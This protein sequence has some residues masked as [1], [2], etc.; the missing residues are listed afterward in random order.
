MHILAKDNK[1]W[2]KEMIRLNRQIAEKEN[3]I[4]KIQEKLDEAIEKNYQHE[5]KEVYLMM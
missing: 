2:E 5:E 1:R 3:Y 4:K